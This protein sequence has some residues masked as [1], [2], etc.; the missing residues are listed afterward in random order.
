VQRHDHCGLE[1]NEPISLHSTLLEKRYIRHGETT[2]NAE[3]MQQRL[4]LSAERQALSRLLEVAKDSDNHQSARVANFLLAWWNP[5]KY[6]RFDLLDAW[7]LDETI[8]KDLVTVFDLISHV[9]SYPDTLGYKE[10]FESLIR[11]SR[12]GMSE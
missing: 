12:P 9:A 10:Q 11:V 1:A 8:R 5:E 6:G 4:M 7:A 3:E 2:L